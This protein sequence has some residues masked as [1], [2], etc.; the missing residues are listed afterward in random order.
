M[1]REWNGIIF[2]TRGFTVEECIE[3]HRKAWEHWPFFNEPRRVWR[4]EN[5]YLCI[6]YVRKEDLATKYYRYVLQDGR[7]GWC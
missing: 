2:E 7:I 4:D 3:A 1:R 6:E 5:D